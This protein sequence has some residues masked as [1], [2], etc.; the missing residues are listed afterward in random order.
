MGEVV[1]RESEELGLFPVLVDGKTEKPIVWAP[2]PGSQVAFLTCPVF[3]CL[4]TGPRGHGK[5]DAILMDFLQHVGVGWKG[6]WRGVLFRRTYPELQD[7]IDKSLKWFPKIFPNAKYNRSEHFWAFE[8]GEQ[9]FFRHF[10]K[11][12]DY[13]KYHGHSYPWQGWEEL[14]TWPD[15]KCYTSMFSCARS[16]AKGIPIKVRATTNPYGVGHNWVKMRFR[17]PIS[18]LGK[19]RSPV[20]RD[21]L[22][23]DGNA[24]PERCA[25]HGSIKE[26]KILI[27]ADPHYIPRIRAAARNPEELRAWLEGDWDIVAGGM[28]DDVWRSEIHVVP[29]IPFNRI[30]RAWRIDR[31]YDHGQAR[32]FSVGWWAESNGEPIQFNDRLYGQVRGDLYRI[33]EWYGWT[34]EPSGGVP[35]LAGDIARGILER[36]ADWGL[37]GRVRAGVADSSIYDDYEP[38]SS[39]AGDMLKVGVSWS[40]SDK[41]PGSRVQGWQQLRKYLTNARE[42]YREEPGMFV[43]ARC[44]QFLRTVPVLP[45]DDLRID[46]VDT[47]AEDHIGDE[48]RYRLRFRGKQVSSGSW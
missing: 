35:L 29:D 38:G 48:V 13:W 22:D 1:W 30:P 4:Y 24:E 6:E 10:E 9:L 15:S 12:V 45:R 33:A 32:P 5:S 27:H 17:L 19:I 11:P 16:T 39:V 41:G 18:P 37:K 14:T 46:D 25:V 43:M 2:Q 31:S 26:N 3:E 20:I 8:E 21:A 28:F 40:R 42:Q 36:E 7:I 44:D 47:D 23:H 34:G